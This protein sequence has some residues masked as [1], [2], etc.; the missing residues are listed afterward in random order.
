MESLLSKISAY[1]LISYALTGLLLTS[2]YIVL[3]GLSPEYN[4]AIIFGAVYLVGLL[5]SRIGSILL[6]WPLKKTGFIQYVPYAEFVEAETIDSKVSGLA[7]QSSFYRTLCCGF[8]LLAGFSAVDGREPIVPNIQGRVETVAF[9]LITCLF[10]FAYK[11]QCKF[12]YDRV[13]TQLTLKGK[14]K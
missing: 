9:F 5:V 7:E 14:P 8:G 10:L 11:K 13:K 2:C 4:P 6:E 3:H 1:H 12:V